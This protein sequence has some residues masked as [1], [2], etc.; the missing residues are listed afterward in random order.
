MHRSEGEVHANDREPE[1]DSSQTLVE[2]LSEHLRPP[3]VHARKQPEHGTTKDD[4]V[5]VS[6]DVIR[7]GLLSVRWCNRVRDTGE[8]TDG[9]LHDDANGVQHRHSES[10][11]SA[12]HGEG[13]VD[14][15]HTRRNSNRHGCDR[16]GCNR[17]RAE[18]RGKHV[19]S[20]DAPTDKADSCAREHDERVTEQR[21]L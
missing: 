12:P 13:P 16:E 10:Q 11:F 8:T 4:V 2:H 14:D 9:E 21:L 18:T 6:D 15:L 20:P 17:N 7:V 1:I 5:E 3:V 19:V